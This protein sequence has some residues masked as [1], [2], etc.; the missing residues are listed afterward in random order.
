MN[1]ELISIIIPAY[2]CQ[3]YVRRCFDS[4]KK[5]TYSNFEAIVINDGST[6]DT[7]TI[8]EEYSKRDSR[9]IIYSKQNGGSSSARNFGLTKVKGNY[10]TWIDSDDDVSNDYLEKLY[11]NLKK[12]DADISICNYTCIKAQEG[13]KENTEE[14]QFKVYST[15]EERA[16]FM[17]NLYNENTII[18][19]VPWAKLFKKNLF[20]GIRFPEGKCFD[21]TATIYKTY[22][23]ANKIVV[24]GEKNYNYYYIDSSISHTL[25]YENMQ[26]MFPILEERIQL[27]TEY[28]YKQLVK[29]TK[30]Y[31]IL[32]LIEY[33]NKHKDLNQDCRI[34]LIN[35]LRSLAL[36]SLFMNN[37]FKRRIKCFLIFLNPK[38]FIK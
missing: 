34:E 12:N 9:F 13:I 31:Y 23:K 2:N 38:L 8:C 24:F 22:L 30:Y 33:L 11:E 17:S 32:Y 15:K 25:Y 1:D 14:L 28:K 37:I 16:K 10:I 36:S 7:K 21:D 6:D 4:I 29:D 18:Y 20:N 35:R 5:Q 27:F 19:V 26:D 3:K